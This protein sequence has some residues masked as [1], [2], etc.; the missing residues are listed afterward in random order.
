MLA[1]ADS[2]YWNVGLVL[3]GSN[4]VTSL[5]VPTKASPEPAE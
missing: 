4:G 2:I 1:V 5:V 3:Y